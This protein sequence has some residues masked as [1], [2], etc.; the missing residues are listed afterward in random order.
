[1]ISSLST[2]FILIFGF[3]SSRVFQ[4]R[5]DRINNCIKVYSAMATSHSI[6]YSGG[7]GFSFLNRVH[8]REIYCEKNLFHD[9]VN[10]G[11][12]EIRLSDNFSQ[13]LED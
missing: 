9:I 12:L 8:A 4:Y 1:M 2:F 5:F 3:N 11:R 10:I 6:G 7:S 13:G